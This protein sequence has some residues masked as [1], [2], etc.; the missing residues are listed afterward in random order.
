LSISLLPSRERKPQRWKKDQ[1]IFH[2]LLRALSGNLRPESGPGNTILAVGRFFLDAPYAAG[3]LE[4][5]GPEALLTNLREFDCFTFV[6]TAVALARV[7]GVGKPSFASFRKE[8]EKIRYRGGQRRG[9]SSRLH[10]FSDWI[11]DNGRKGIIENVTPALGGRAFRKAIGFMTSHS[12]L[13]PALRD[14]LELRKIRR[15]EKTI[16]ARSVFFLPKDRLKPSEPLLRDGDIIAVTTEREDLD[17]Q[18]V[19]FAARTGKGVHL[20]HASSAE[21]RVVLSDQ[22]L[23]RYLKEKKERSGILAARIR[24][25]RK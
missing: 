7:L 24:P 2:A 18:H 14:E 17:V 21:G 1:E 11:R 15:M 25:I 22:T 4:S 6:E 9:Y 20:L 19:G 5:N 12:D 13:Y 10:Y 23:Y 8:I 3:P 16:S